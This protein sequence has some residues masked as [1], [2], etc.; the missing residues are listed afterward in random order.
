MDNYIDY[1]ILLFSWSTI[2]MHKCEI[3]TAWAMLDMVN[4]MIKDEYI[5][6]SVSSRESYWKFYCISILSCE[7]GYVSFISL[8]FCRV[9]YRYTLNLTPR[10]V[11]SKSIILW[12][13]LV[14]IQYSPAISHCI[15][16][17]SIEYSG[18]ILTVE[19]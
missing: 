5:T 11:S 4:N 8:A 6:Q 14:N 15:C 10:T 7:V 13:L 9:V 3:I 16:H 1:L 2:C 12:F 17:G 18:S 19:W